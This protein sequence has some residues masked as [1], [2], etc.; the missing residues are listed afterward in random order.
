MKYYR[1]NFQRGNDW[2]YITYRAASLEALIA[3]C[4]RAFTVYNWRIASA[5][6]VRQTKARGCMIL[7][8]D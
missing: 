2:N 3:F 1:V 7:T 6:E 8:L 4:D 5:S